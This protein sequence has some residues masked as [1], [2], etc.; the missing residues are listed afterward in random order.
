MGLDRSRAFV[1]GEIQVR[2]RVLA[3]EGRDGVVK[4]GCS[5]SCAGEV[6]PGVFLFHRNGASPSS[7][8]GGV[9]ARQRVLWSTASNVAINGVEN[10]KSTYKN[11]PDL[12]S[13]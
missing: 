7:L 11:N 2:C 1:V 12:H 9:H 13:S 3:I 8:G 10:E 4:I 6:V 5:D